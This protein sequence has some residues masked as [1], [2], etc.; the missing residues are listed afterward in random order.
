MSSK[1]NISKTYT[2]LMNFPTFEERFQYLKLSSI[3]GE[4]TFNGFR[5]LNQILYKSYEWKM[6]RRTVIIRDD[7]CDLADP[8]YPILGE[9]YIHHIVPLTIEDI[10]ERRYCVFDPD[11]LICCSFATHNAIH[12]SDEVITRKPV[13]RKPNDTCLWR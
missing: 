10:L 8:D 12:Y 6:A 3:V 13:V 11:N 2:E 9:I 1:T 5:Q 4:F 7:G